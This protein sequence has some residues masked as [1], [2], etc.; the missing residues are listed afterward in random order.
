MND[1]TNFHTRNVCVLMRKGTMHLVAWWAACVVAMP[2]CCRREDAFAHKFFILFLQH[3]YCFY[4]MFF[5][6]KV[7]C[8]VHAAAYNSH[9]RFTT[10]LSNVCEQRVGFN[11]LL[12]LTVLLLLGLV[13]HLASCNALNCEGSCVSVIASPPKT[14]WHEGLFK[15]CCRLSVLILVLSSNICEWV[16]SQLMGYD[17]KPPAG[18][19]FNVAHE[20]RYLY[21]LSEH[22]MT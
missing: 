8:E 16:W 5:N 13:V 22:V 9:G 17:L 15:I 1:F 3:V 12:V 21:I 20:I 18:V 4:F 11:E 19:M 14:P 2:L 10:I 6:F 7:Q